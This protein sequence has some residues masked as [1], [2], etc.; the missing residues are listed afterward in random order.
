MKTARTIIASLLLGTLVLSSPATVFASVQQAVRTS[1]TAASMTSSGELRA[2]AAGA[3][4]GGNKAVMKQPDGKKK[5]AANRPGNKPAGKPGVA[6]G[7]ARPGG[8]APAP[9]HP[10][11]YHHHDHDGVVTGAALLLGVLIGSAAA[12]SGD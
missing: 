3:R 7:G 12:S 11:H 8:G 10:R 4:P 2:K 9:G 6:H 5:P 1:G